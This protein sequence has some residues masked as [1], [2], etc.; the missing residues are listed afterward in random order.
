[1]VIYS[2]NQRN[3]I[4]LL[5]KAYGFVIFTSI[6]LFPGMMVLFFS[7]PKEIHPSMKE[8]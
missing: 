8:N 1:M 5:A 6:Q 4:T 7:F 2:S 3:I